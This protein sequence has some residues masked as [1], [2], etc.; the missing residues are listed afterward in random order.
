MRA[1]VH[2]HVWVCECMC[3]RMCVHVRVWS[4]WGLRVRTD[5]GGTSSS[6]WWGRLSLCATQLPS[7]EFLGIV[8][9]LLTTLPVE[10]RIAGVWYSIRLVI[11]LYFC[12]VRLSYNVFLFYWFPSPKSPPQSGFIMWVLRIKPELSGLCSNT[13]SAEPSCQP[14][15]CIF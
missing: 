8:P 14:L 11:H 7:T 9:S 15:L 12:F 3:M 5:L 6:P 4:N 10:H 13:W 1:S 2:V